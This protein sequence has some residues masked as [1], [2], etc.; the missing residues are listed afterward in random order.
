MGLGWRVH[1]AGR[2]QSCRLRARAG[3]TQQTQE[4]PR[5]TV[6]LVWGF[7]GILRATPSLKKGKKG[8]LRVLESVAPPDELL[9]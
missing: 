5:K 4:Y 2:S 8:L 3:R 1:E 7:K 9:L 6:V